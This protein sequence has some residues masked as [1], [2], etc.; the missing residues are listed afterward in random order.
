[1]I[2]ITRSRAV[3]ETQSGA[4]KI[5]RSSR[6]NDGLDAAK[7]AAAA[8]MIVNHVLIALPQPW[9]YWGNLAGRP[10]IPIFCFIIIKRIAD[11]TPARAIRMLYWLIPW[12]L[13]SQPIYQLLVINFIIRANILVTLAIGVGLI[14]LLSRRLYMYLPIALLILL[15][16]NKYL[17]GG[18]ITVA[19]MLTAYALN[20]FYSYAA[21][22]T[23]TVAAMAS[24]LLLTPQAP[25]ASLCVLAAPLII[26]VSPV[27]STVCPRLPRAAFYAFYPAHLLVI[28]LVFGPYG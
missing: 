19:G 20:R 3:S 25:E 27:F 13:L 4:D 1:M 7:F 2:P 5:V 12:A 16:A 23:V 11:N 6:Q 26:G 14:Y 9:P 28:L 18:A 21:L 15:F 22:P 24:N 8:L 10:C 17:D